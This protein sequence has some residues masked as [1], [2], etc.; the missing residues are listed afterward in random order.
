MPT[1]AGNHS[2]EESQTQIKPVKIILLDV[3]YFPLSFPFL[4]A[5]FSVYCYIVIRMTEIICCLMWLLRNT[6]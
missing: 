3:V 6:I 1:K 2:L 4:D 5:F